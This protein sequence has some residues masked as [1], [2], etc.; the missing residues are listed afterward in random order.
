M[1]LWQEVRFQFGKGW[2]P[3]LLRMCVAFDWVRISGSKLVERCKVSG[4]TVMHVCASVC[5]LRC[6][7]DGWKWKVPVP[8]ECFL[9][10][11]HTKIIGGCQHDTR[12]LLGVGATHLS[13]AENYIHNWNYVQNTFSQ[14][15][16]LLFIF[17]TFLLCK[18]VYLL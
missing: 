6:L 10:F 1:W 9:S 7:K 15:L 16:T 13:D 12:G 18:I 14:I 4:A 17:L 5:L 3:K 2:G 8:F 11:N